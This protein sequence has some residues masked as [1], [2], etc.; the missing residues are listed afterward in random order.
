MR[1]KLKQVVKL[2]GVLA[3]VAGVL[4]LMYAGH[5]ADKA[6]GAFDSVP[7]QDTVVLEMPALSVF[8]DTLLEECGGKAYSPALRAV[9]SEQMQR[10]AQKWLKGLAQYAWAALPCLET[11]MG[12]HKTM[13]S[14]AGAKGI[15]QMMDSTAKA[16][17]VRCG[18]GE[19]TPQD[20]HD[21]ELNLNLSACHFAALVEQHGVEL[22]PYAYNGGSGSE[23]LRLAKK[24]MPGG[25]KETLGYASI[26]SVIM[27]RFLQEKP[28]GRSSK[29]VAPAAPVAVVEEKK[30]GI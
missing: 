10:V 27:F 20:L 24:L 6:K 12:T 22:A 2:V 4:T 5:Q 18:Y 14:T 7:K 26:H 17:A 29:Q 13:I 15:V 25:A 23:A 1:Q 28:V 16:E 19:L 30:E 9:R 21:A 3:L 11:R 8:T